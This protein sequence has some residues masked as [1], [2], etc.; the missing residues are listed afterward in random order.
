[1]EKSK[2]V[3]SASNYSM[4]VTRSLIGQQLASEHQVDSALEE[5]G[6][7]IR[8]LEDLT[9]RDPKNALWQNALATA[10]LFSG[11]ALAQSGRADDALAE[12]R[13][14]GEIWSKLVEDNNDNVQALIGLLNYHNE[15]TGMLQ[16][17]QRHGEAVRE[18][19]LGEALLQRIFAHLAG[20]NYVLLRR[21]S[22]NENGLVETYYT[23]KGQ[24]FAP[25]SPGYAVARIEYD[26]AGNMNEVAFYGTDGNLVVAPMYGFAILR[27]EYN[28][29]GQLV[30]EVYYDANGELIPK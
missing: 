20:G 19:Q 11:F 25:P 14:G 2:T 18:S 22:S 24:L 8:V 7:A 28:K 16:R 6:K 13:R 5:H 10:Y 12:Y 23:E 9:L 29:G 1:M 30:Q 26:T 27:R 4:A 21:P 3:D 17:Q 15:V